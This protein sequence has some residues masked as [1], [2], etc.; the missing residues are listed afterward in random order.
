MTTHPKEPLTLV[1]WAALDS[2]YC[3]SRAR[4]YPSAFPNTAHRGGCNDAAKD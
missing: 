4:C 2:L 1:K 3:G